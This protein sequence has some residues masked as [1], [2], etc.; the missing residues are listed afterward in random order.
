MYNI[1]MKS[2]ILI[3]I[4]GIIFL[5]VLAFTIGYKLEGFEHHEFKKNPDGL[6]YVTLED[7][8]IYGDEGYE[9]DHHEGYENEHHEGFSSLNEAYENEHH[10]GFEEGEKVMVEGFTG[11]QTSPYGLENK[12]DVFSQLPSNKTCPAVGLHNSMGNLC[13]DEKSRKLMGTRGGNAT[14]RPDEF[15]SN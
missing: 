8:G 6:P 2:T 12:L 5:M 10:E 7:F 14:G 13:L 4:A 9:N 1:I 15:G 3:I 11:L